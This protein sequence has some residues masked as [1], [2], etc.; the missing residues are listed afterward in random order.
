MQG[1]LR[2]QSKAVLVLQT[3]P[4]VPPPVL[5]QDPSVADGRSLPDAK[6]PCGDDASQR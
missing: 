1:S 4:W 3:Q 5:A 6:A 2:N